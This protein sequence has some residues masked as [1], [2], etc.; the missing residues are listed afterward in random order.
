MRQA[1][2]QTFETA[3]IP[4]PTGGIN[5][6]NAGSAMPPEDC[7]WLWNML[8]SEHGLRVRPG[9][10]EWAIN[11]TGAADNQVRTTIP[12]TGSAQNGASNK[13]FAC[14]SSGIWD[15]T[16]SGTSPSQ[17][18]TFADQSGDAGYGVHHAV[19]TPAGRF[20]LYCDEVNGLYVWSESASAWSRPAAGVNQEWAAST[21]YAAGNQA[22][23][24]GNAYLC[25]VGGTS[26]ASGGPT[27]TGTGIADG[28]VTWNYVS[29]AVA[30]TI[31]PCLA[32]QN[33]GYT[34]DPANFAH[35]TVFKSRVWFVER[36]TSR[37]Y[38]LDANAIYGT[39]TSFDFG[40]KMKAGGP[41]AGLFGWSYDGGNGLDTLLVGI[42]LA[43]DVVIYQ[44]TD[45][46]YADTFGIKGCWSV[47]A[48]PAGRT[49][50]T[51]YGGDLL[52]LSSL[53]AVPLSKLVVGGAEV[54]DALY[55][56]FKVSN[57]LNT[58][59]ATGRTLR[60][61]AIHIHPTD[62]AL[63]ITA[64]ATSGDATEQLVMSFAT[65]GWSRYRDLPILSAATWNR[66]FYFGTADGRVCR[67][68]ECLDEVKLDGTG[69]EAIQYSAL[70]AYRNLGSMRQKQVHF[71]RPVLLTAD[72]SPVVQ[73]T[74]LFDFDLVEP[75]APSGSPSG[76]WDSGLW[77]DELW[78]G[79]YAP[80]EVIDGG[81][82]MG[83]YV[84]IAIRG[85]A[86]SK[87]VLVGFDV[88]LEQGGIL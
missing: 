16:D 42:S 8:S 35:V 70:T 39:A 64:P 74:A 28:S 81:A 77:D 29:A 60:G 72:R 83:R 45:P 48:I 87:T 27:G 55:A 3:T 84:G 75:D 46:A 63:I 26:A 41:L 88:S 5:T 7:V 51:D 82:G 1:K 17:L 2:R 85:S 23:N 56:T 86:S 54:S 22:I 76:G 61:W 36:N 73:C 52:V 11:L 37:T 4:A 12:F 67:Q 66:E 53:G 44:G 34:A 65:R 57:L 18:V 68:I 58:L 43:G 69:N 25:A 13:L 38:Y 9:F 71:I 20:L 19:A 80:A 24:D 47:G 14:T 59:M 15:V 79:E 62:N 32:D 40:S 33:L 30:N 6:V 49:I 10:A 78:G 21:V 50:A 31:G